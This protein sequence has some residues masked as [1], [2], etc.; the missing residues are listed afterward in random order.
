M[1]FG[2]EQVVHQ[3]NPNPE[4]PNLPYVEVADYSDL[5]GLPKIEHKGRVTDLFNGEHFVDIIRDTPKPMRPPSLVMFH[6][7][8]AC[9]NFEKELD[10][11]YHAENTLPA[12]E[13]LFIT[14]YDFDRAPR[15]N[16]YKFTPERDL[17]KR[18]GLSGCELVWVQQCAHMVWCEQASKPGSKLSVVGCEDFKEPCSGIEV[19]DGEGSWVSWVEGKLEASGW[20]QLNSIWNTYNFQGQFIQSRSD[21]TT[22]TFLRNSFM[23]T[24]VPA[25]TK[26]G[27]KAVETPPELQTFLIDFYKSKQGAIGYDEKMHFSETQNSHPETTARI[28]S[29]STRA[30]LAN[31]Y[32]RP[33]VSEWSGIPEEHLTMTSFYGIREY[34]PGHFLRNHIDRLDTHVLSLTLSIAKLDKQGEILPQH[35]N[36]NQNRTAWPL[37]W[38]GYDGLNTRHEHPPGTTLL[39]E[40]AKII[41]GRPDRQPVDA[42]LHLGAFA[43]YA[44]SDAIIDWEN[45]VDRARKIVWKH[46]KRM[47]YK[48]TRSV[49]PRTPVLTDRPYAK[50]GIDDVGPSENSHKLSADFINNSPET[51]SLF[52]A[53]DDGDFIENCQSVRSK[54]KCDIGTYPGH[55]FGWGKNVKGV[56]KVIKSSKTKVRKG[57]TVYSYDGKIAFKNAEYAD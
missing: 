18:F 56:N 49:E 30:D 15:L 41:H 14:K 5:K 32:L 16:W 48:Q 12:R 24:K 26:S 35:Y 46:T 23:A 55:V 37:E 34:H 40:S 7:F 44:P 28:I 53:S 33:L 6:G 51:L 11:S 20:P 3:D 36:P 1:V 17:H 52:W 9:P 38:V 19:W 42:G 43:H 39:Y 31:K 29:I 8:E 47:D 21:V 13:R 50:I 22:N 25:F 4:F 10:Y 57:Q 27:V 54:G 45:T 2:V